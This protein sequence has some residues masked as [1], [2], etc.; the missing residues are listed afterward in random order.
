MCA[1][2]VDHY[3]TREQRHNIVPSL[4]SMDRLASYC[5][6][7]PGAGS[8]AASLQTRAVRKGDHFLIN[9]SKV[10]G[11]AYVIVEV[12]IPGLY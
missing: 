12:H 2:M 9:G 5:L 8:D 7:E 4:C 10:G 1:W 11:T 3:G 6:T